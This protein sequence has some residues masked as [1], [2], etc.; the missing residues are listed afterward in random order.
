MKNY[1]AG[2]LPNAEL[3]A[4]ATYQSDAI[5]VNISALGN[6]FGFAA[7]KDQY[8]ATIDINQLIYDWGRIKAAKQLESSDLQVKQQNTQVEL[9]RLKEQINR[10]YFSILI[11][12]KNEELMIV[13]LNDVENQEK[14]VES[15]VK[16]GLMLNSNLNSIKAEK[17]KLKQSITE[18]INQRLA[19]IQI[20]AE[21]TG[22]DLSSDVALEMPNYEVNEDAKL[23]RPEHQLFDL[24]MQK[25]DVSGK[26]IAKQNDPVLYSFAQ[27]GYGKPGMNMVNDEFD[28]FYII[29]VGLSWNIWDWNQT[30]RKKQVALI[31]KGLINT[32]KET[33]DKQI[34]ISVH[35]ELAK[36]ASMQ[37]TI[38]S[39]KEIISLRE[40]VTKSAR[41]KLENGAITST[42]YVT[43]LS[44]ETQAKINYET[45]KIQLIQSK[46]NF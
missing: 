16:N 24:Q 11:L 1:Q 43:E 37:S 33:F 23:F 3:N 30:K 38:L 7:E 45:H 31:N 4:K 35:N 25:L 29:G 20:L 39:D 34:M 19:A 40:E 10:F 12:Q 8:Q 2:W 41:S 28:S 18:I 9:N 22:M 27:V 36:I 5:D 26:L 44:A 21:I 14:V 13:M 6:N 46:V 32:Q 15:A 42:D 17:L